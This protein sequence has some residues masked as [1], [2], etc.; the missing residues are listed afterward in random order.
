MSYIGTLFN[1]FLLVGIADVRV[2]F[3]STLSLFE[4]VVNRLSQCRGSLWSSVIL[5]QSLGDGSTNLVE[6]LDSLDVGR[7]GGF[8]T[9]VGVEPFLLCVQSSQ[10][11]FLFFR[12]NIRSESTVELASLVVDHLLQGILAVGSVDDELVVGVHL[13]FSLLELS[14]DRSILGAETRDNGQV[15]LS[16]QLLDSLLDRLWCLTLGLDGIRVWDLLFPLDLLNGVGSL[17]VEDA[18]QVEPRLD[19]DNGV[20]SVGVR[21]DTLDCELT[22]EGV[23]ALGELLWVG[24]VSFQGE[25]LL[26]V[27]GK[28]LGRWNRVVW[29]EDEELSLFVDIGLFPSDLDRVRG[30]VVDG[31]VSNSEDGRESSAGQCASSSYGFVLVGGEGQGLATEEGRD[32]L[33][34]SRDSRASSDHFDRVDV[35]LLETSLG[36]GGLEGLCEPFDQGGR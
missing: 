36:K 34:E 21:L 4:E 20:V 19:L 27:E 14:E 11:L 30:D 8:F 16:L 25:G 2:L 12:L 33:L 22:E 31:K 29:L 28:D 6:L 26:A 32:S 7:L 10:V 5:G 3:V 24:V 13:T 18:V 15:V 35:L 1:D 23:D 9:F 17:E